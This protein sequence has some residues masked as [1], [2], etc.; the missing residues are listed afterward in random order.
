MNGAGEIQVITGEGKGKTTTALGMALLAI[1]RGMRVFMVQFLKA[2]D[3]SGEHFAVKRFEPMMTLKPMG[4]EGFI[5]RRGLEPEDTVMAQRALVEAR[6]AM[7][8][9]EYQL[10]ILDEVN[11]AIHLGILDV[12]QL[13][14]FLDSK[15]REVEL[16][17]TGRH[18]HPE[19]VARADVVLEMRKVK[20]HFDSGIGAREGIDY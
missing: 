9:G 1:N 18:A 8:T 20:H 10:V 4:R 16:V 5:F 17:L 11:V 13:L 19:L 7:L 14:E 6:N 2:P 3:T 15:P 12:E